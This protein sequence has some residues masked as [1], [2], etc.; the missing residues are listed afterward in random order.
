M[1]TRCARG[2]DTVNYHFEGL[3]LDPDR[4][5]LRAGDALLNLQPRVFDLVL[6]LVRHRDRV[7][8]KDELLDQLWPGVIVVEGALQRA[9]SLARSHLREAC[10]VNCIRTHA[11][12]GYRFIVE[13]CEEGSAQSADGSGAVQAPARQ[14]HAKPV[15]V[16]LPFE[17]LSSDPEQ[18]FFA[19]GIAE[20]I[21]TGLSR[22]RCLVV[23]SR[24]SSM[25][26]GDRATDPA[27]AAG[28]LGARYV[29]TGSV[30]RAGERLRVHVELIDAASRGQIWAETFDRQTVNL[31]E[32]QD[33]ITAT[34]VAKIEPE[35]SQ[36]EREHA[37]V[38]SPDSL[39]A[40]GA[41]QRGIWHMY[42]FTRADS[43][44]SRPLFEQAISLDPQFAPAHA[45][46]SF[47]HFVDAYLGYDEDWQQSAEQALAAARRGVTADNRCPAAHWALGRALLLRGELDAAQDEIET[48]IEL[49][50]NFAHAYYMLGWVQVLSGN[51]GGA[52][53]SLDN[54]EKL[55]PRDPLLFAFSM[56]RAMALL[57]QDMP[58]SALKYSEQA[59]RQTNSHQHTLAVHI[60][61]L[62]ACA[63]LDKA[64]IAA[65]RL[66]ELDPDYS[67]AA[68]ARAMPY[69][70]QEDLASVTGGLRQVGIA[71][72]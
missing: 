54:A 23:I 36:F 38:Q 47:C 34:V 65:A 6:Y 30:R 27:T 19:E 17:N 39:D 20:D 57:L 18:A 43:I 41:Y 21:S 58:E 56:T 63:E 69:R 67:C 1:V 16:V 13:V 64:K 14:L 35:F 9:I 24:A 26:Y 46:A 12:R 4:R 51:P 33:D 60:A 11:R 37:R 29:L 61:A 3:V 49:N 28:E 66:L 5:E 59:V 48:S 15:I 2:V 22:L 40:W 62:A 32:I 42:Q 7:V 53:Q 50:P 31:F 8:S 68:F 10:G 71:C 45:G 52:L 55:S 25:I 72:E 70:S 44:Q